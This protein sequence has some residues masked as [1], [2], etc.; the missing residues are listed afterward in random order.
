MAKGG[1]AGMET[2]EAVEEAGGF[3]GMRVAKARVADEGEVVDRGVAGGEGAG[4][5]VVRWC[6]YRCYF[7]PNVFVDV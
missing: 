1:R 4:V 5:G 6:R 3:E 2:A 7:G